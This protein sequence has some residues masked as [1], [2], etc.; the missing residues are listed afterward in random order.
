M[1]QF[2]S[3]QYYVDTSPSEFDCTRPQPY[4]ADTIL[5]HLKD[6]VDNGQGSQIVVGNIGLWENK[7]L[8][9]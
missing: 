5:R 1:C 8:Q 9:F 4:Y 7:L 3:T 6:I 2:Q